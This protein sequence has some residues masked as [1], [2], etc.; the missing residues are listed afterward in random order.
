MNALLLKFTLKSDATFGRG[1]GVAG[2]VDE[3]VQHDECGLP[4][5]NG[6]T[7]KGLLAAECAEILA[8]FVQVQPTQTQ[9]WE[10]AA[11][12]LFGKGG[13]DTEA[14]GHLRVCGAF[15]GRF[16]RGGD[17]TGAARRFQTR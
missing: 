2:L 6:R 14:I 3:E 13:S 7:L 5:L 15:A 4:F 1:D 17:A 16:V 11:V 9:E 8:V 12:W 10:R